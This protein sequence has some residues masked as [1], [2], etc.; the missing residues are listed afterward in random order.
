[1]SDASLIK[2]LQSDDEEAFR[3]LVEDYR[4]RVINTCYRFIRNRE[5]AED[6]AQEVFIEVYRSIGGFRRQA[7]LSTWIYR[8][9]V[10]RSLDFIRRRDRKKRFGS[11]RAVLGFHHDEAVRLPAPARSSPAHDLEHQERRRILQQ[12]LNALPDSQQAAITLSKMEGFSTRE[13]AEIMGTTVPSV[14]ALI[15]RAKAGLRKKLRRYYEKKL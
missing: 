3:R 1:M 4:H 12:A 15:H 2:L 6:V 14:E 10:T 9:A 5:D 11:V 13:I 8:I 7:R